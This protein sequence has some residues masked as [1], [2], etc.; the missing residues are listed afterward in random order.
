MY[1]N[2][3]GSVLDALYVLTN[4]IPESFTVGHRYR[5]LFE[6]Y[7]IDIVKP[8]ITLTQERQRQQKTKEQQP[9]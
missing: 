7:N 8:D 1:W 6:K 5:E 9:K 3:A 2:T 4:T